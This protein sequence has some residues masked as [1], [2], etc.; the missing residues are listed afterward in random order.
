ML[1]AEGGNNPGGGRA[2]MSNLPE[3]TRN[4]V[5]D[6]PAFDFEAPSTFYVHL[7]SGD[8][9]IVTDVTSL[10][11]TDTELVFRRRAKA[12]ERFSRRDVYYA[13]CEEDD[14]PPSLF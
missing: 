12:P 10:D 4:L 2:T 9:K 14:E 8:V 1:E 7:D 13:C 6:E 3:P 11:V 5:R